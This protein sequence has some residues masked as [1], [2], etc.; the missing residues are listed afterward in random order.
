MKVAS[1][2][3][4]Q[5]MGAAFVSVR[6]R[7]LTDEERRLTP[8]LQGTKQTY[9]VTEYLTQSSSVLSAT[10]SHPPNYYYCKQVKMI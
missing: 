2:E 3:W 1:M 8:P 4:V 7:P 10:L 9:K 6:Q 5:Q